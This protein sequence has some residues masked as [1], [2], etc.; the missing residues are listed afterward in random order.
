[1]RSSAGDRAERVDSIVRAH[2]GTDLDRFVA[3]VAA[4]TTAVVS[5]TITEGAYSEDATAADEALLARLGDGSTTARPSSALGRVLLGLDARRRAGAPPIA[6]VSCDNVPDNGGVLKRALG[7]L[8][9]PAADLAAWIDRNVSFVSSSVDRITPR[10]SH[11]DAARLSE[12]YGDRAPVVT[13]PFTDWVLSG[14]FPAGRPDWESAGA[15]VVDELEPWEARKLWMLN[16][17]HTLLASLGRIRGHDTVAEAIA[18][19]E[20]FRAVEAYWDEVCRHL[21][22]ELDLYDYRTALVER[23]TNPRI[24]HRLAQ[25]AEGAET[26][27]ALRIV[28][29]ALRERAAGR[30]ADASATAIAAWIAVEGHTEGVAAVRS[31]LGRVSAELAGDDDFVAAVLH[32]RADLDI[33]TLG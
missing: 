13:E 28:P 29:V 2:A 30:P 12:R 31:A 17:A 16:G 8:A 11:D 4:P 1:V 14:V 24:V 10:L 6:L 20:C 3:D 18:D 32:A 26:K 9:A 27:I 25:I 22:P 23:F 7:R 15:R 5:L 33:L 19:R 21:P